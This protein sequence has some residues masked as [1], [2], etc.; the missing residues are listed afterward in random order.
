L[1]EMALYTGAPRS[2]STV[3]IEDCDLY[4]LDNKAFQDL[5]KRHPTEA[6]LLHSFIVRLMSERLARANKEIMALSR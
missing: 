5:N 2:A 4:R 1:G 3:V 6:G